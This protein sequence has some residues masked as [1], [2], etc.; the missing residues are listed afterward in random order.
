MLVSHP[1]TE[2]GGALPEP[3]SASV[4]TRG[5]ALSGSSKTYPYP[6][7]FSSFF[8]GLG[9]GIVDIGGLH[10]PLLPQDP[11]E[12][13]GAEAPQLFQWDLR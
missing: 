10:G 11:L 8:S 5:R 9:P 7:F 1:Q 13:V 4:T 12:K 6:R 2:S 3:R